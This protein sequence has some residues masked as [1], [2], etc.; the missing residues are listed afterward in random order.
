[1]SQ[2]RFWVLFSKKIAAEASSDEIS[3]LENLIQEHPEWQFAV[4]NLEDLWNHQPKPLDTLD[5]ED[6]YILH[7]N[8]I[9][10]LQI[11]FGDYQIEAPVYSL[12]RN[13]KWYWAAA[14]LLVASA[15]LFALL[16]INKREK[17][18]SPV[19]YVNEVSTRPG[20]KSK[21]Q[22]PD[23]SMVWL[24]AGSKLTYTKDFGKKNREVMLTG[25]AFFDVT[26]NPEKPFLIQTNSINIKVLGTAFNVKAY[27][28]DKQTE[29]SLIRG[30]IEVTI[31]NRPND[32][33]FLSPSEKLVVENSSVAENKKSFIN[34]GK[35]NRPTTAENI[36]PALLVPKL[37]INKLKYSP[38]DSTVA[39]TQWINN[40]LVFRDESFADLAIRLERWYDVTIEINDGA[41]EEARFNGIF[42]SETIVQALEALKISVPFVYEQ[43]GNKITIHK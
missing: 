23:G 26:K 40:R 6:A 42:Q 28:E 3:E 39:E 34:P 24:N 41:L 10:E 38:V 19:S 30:N 5:P 2:E 21:I 11:P 7:L 12:Q 29:T 16:Q 17:N 15:G 27:P 37:S 33:I 36:T 14:I 18:S 4:Q 22:L 25:E 9:N 31:K 35:T 43:K 13:K 1:M 8:R 20:S 32:K